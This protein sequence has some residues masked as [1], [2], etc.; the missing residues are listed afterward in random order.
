ELLARTFP[1][2]ERVETIAQL[3][4][5]S[6]EH[7]TPAARRGFLF[8]AF[9]ELFRRMSR[10]LPMILLVED[11]QLADADGQALLRALLAP[12]GDAR[13]LFVGT[14]RTDPPALL[15]STLVQ[16]LESISTLALQPLDSYDSESLVRALW[17]GAS[18]GEVRRVLKQASGH[19]LFMRELCLSRTS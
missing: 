7:L 8:G 18:D 1:V 16:G 19:P 4:L 3:P 17:T 10:H 12:P 5:K 13:I 6:F 2:L 14:L 15:P 11:L 9:R